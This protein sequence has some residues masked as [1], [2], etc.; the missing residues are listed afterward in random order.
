VKA[1]RDTWKLGIHSYLAYL[2]D[3]LNVARDLL[4]ETG[5]I[6]VQIGDENV[7]RIRCV[8][9]EVFGDTNFCAEITFRKTSGIE[10]DLL[11]T[12]KDWLLWY[13]KDKPQVKFRRLFLEKRPGEAGAEQFEWIEDDMGNIRRAT[14][15]E[16]AER[17]T[18]PAGYRLLSHNDPTAVGF[19]TTT[20]YVLSFQ[21]SDYRL[22]P[23]RR[24]RSTPDGMRRME[25]AGRL[26]AIGNTLRQKRYYSDYPVYALTDWW[27]D[28]GISGFGDKKIYVV[29]QY[30]RQL[31]RAE[32][33]LTAVN[34]TQSGQPAEDTS[35]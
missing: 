7:H 14:P 30:L 23:N 26:F 19:A 11:A 35:Q 32:S 28:T 18:L 22:A 13:A 29:Q 33:G 12:S 15:D 17:V 3:R 8:L 34:P 5:S 20:D 10:S 24:W 1:F 6:F 25:M 4:T 27:E 31:R 21:G 9:D 2:R 16:M